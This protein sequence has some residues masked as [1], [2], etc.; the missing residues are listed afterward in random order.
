MTTD[1]G[2]TPSANKEEHDGYVYV[3]GS[4]DFGPQYDGAM[5]IKVRGNSTKNYAKKPWK[6]KLDKKTDMFGFGKS[7]HWVLLAN[8]NDM[9]QMRGR[10]AA[11]LA[12]DIGSS[13]MDSTWVECVLNGELQ[14]LYQFSE[15]IRVDENRVDIFD[16]E[17]LGEDVGK[18]IYKNKKNAYDDVIAA[19]DAAGVAYDQD[20]YETLFSEN[21]SWVNTG[22]LSL[23]GGARIDVSGVP[24]TTGLDITG[25]Y[26]FELSEEYDDPSKFTTYSG[27]LQV[28]TMF[29]RPEM[30]GTSTAMMDWCRGY[31]QDYWDAVTSATRRNSKGRYYTEYA[32]M[33]SMV[34]FTLVN[35]LFAN[36]DA[37]KKSR[38]V[39]I[40]RGGKLVFG[41][42]WDFDWGCS[43]IRVGQ[44]PEYW[45]CSKDEDPERS[46]PYSIQKEWASDVNFCR[47]L[48][49]R[50]W[51]IRG[52]YEEIF[53]DGGL[54]DRYAEVLA[55]AGR[56]DDDL[57]W[58][59]RSR[60]ERRTAADDIAILKSFLARRALWLDA[61]F[62]S[63]ETL[64]RSLKCSI[65]S[66]PADIDN[67]EIWEPDAVRESETLADGTVVPE[68]AL[69]WIRDA[70][71]PV[72]AGWGWASVQEL[73]DAA[74]AV[75]TARGKETPLWQDYV[76]GTDPDPDGED[77][78]LRITE[79]DI[80]AEGSVG[81]IEMDW[82]PNLGDRRRYTILGRREL[83]DEGGWHEA[84][85]GDRFFTVRV[86]MP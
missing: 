67:I 61:Q 19:L 15:Q 83:D 71:E 40:D 3:Q 36:N 23:D 66:S 27:N 51:E 21:L 82:R 81:S 1:D 72:D 4:A 52:R 44:S 79:F 78:A 48:Y 34:A 7:K 45:A 32:D 49:T 75:P 13:G 16:W 33:D 46:K 69:A 68:I 65:Q 64:M 35:E 55:E 74:V 11:D 28:K 8:Y 22:T 73:K 29:S 85:D 54:I 25:G 70:L 26:I 60:D 56:V 53:R 24:D 5:S 50:Y 2:Q 30:A 17:S 38:Y 63:V 18:T 84:E 10:L 86:D 57:W 43:S 80:D 31:M 39:Y 58:S 62:A 47:R 37:K 77:A 20:V 12:N 59:R 41:P 76:A 6:I 42:V 9:A 14:G